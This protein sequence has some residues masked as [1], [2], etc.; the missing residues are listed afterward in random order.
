MN[1]MSTNAPEGI[2]IFKRPVSAYC[3][4]RWDNFNNYCGMSFYALAYR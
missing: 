3:G 2:K 1:D 4:S